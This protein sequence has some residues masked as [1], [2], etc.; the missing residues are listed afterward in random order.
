MSHGKPCEASCSRTQLFYR[1]SGSLALSLWS[2][3]PGTAISLPARSHRRMLTAFGSGR[4]STICLRLRPNDRTT[5]PKTHESINPFFR[6]AWPPA[7]ETILLSLSRL[8]LGSSD[9]NM[10]ISR[11][12]IEGSYS[13]FEKVQSEDVRCSILLLSFSAGRRWWS[14]RR[15]ARSQSRRHKWLNFAITIL[16]RSEW[17]KEERK[18]MNDQTFRERGR[19]QGGKR[20]TPT[21]N[22]QRLIY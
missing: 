19:R 22:L 5:D 17:N 14:K 4:P 12:R 6:L 10:K 15:R 1:Q 9:P 7:C 3:A 2:A 13:L 21:D 16:S 11:I 18:E 8:S 20:Q